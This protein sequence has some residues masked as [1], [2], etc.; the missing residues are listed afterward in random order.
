MARDYFGKTKKI[1]KVVD[2]IE[3][4]KA[5]NDLIENQDERH[6]AK[7]NPVHFFGEYGISWPNDWGFNFDIRSGVITITVSANTSIFG[8]KYDLN[9][10]ITLSPIKDD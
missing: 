7:N 10:Q 6:L 5:C 2:S 9:M 3:F 4:G 8:K 1:R